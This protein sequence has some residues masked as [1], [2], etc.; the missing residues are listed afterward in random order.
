MCVG[1]IEVSVLYCLCYF[2]SSLGGASYRVAND[3]RHCALRRLSRLLSFCFLALLPPGSGVSAWKV[4]AGRSVSSPR[5]ES[6]SWQLAN[7][8]Y[9]KR[10]GRRVDPQYANFCQRGSKR[11]ADK[12]VGAGFTSC[13]ALREGK[14]LSASQGRKTRETDF[15]VFQLSSLSFLLAVFNTD[16]YN[17][18]WNIGSERPSRIP[19][20][21][22]A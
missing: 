7:R 2:H 8:F 17:T 19:C 11:K 4:R 20:F 12:N 10:G 13:L 16:N 5:P 15:R 21:L 3:L 1:V 18:T 22:L 6:A 14:P 9:A